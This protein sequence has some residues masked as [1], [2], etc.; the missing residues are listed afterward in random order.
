MDTEPR[1]QYQG[2]TEAAV[3]DALTE[4]GPNHEIVQEVFR[5]VA[6]YASFLE[7]HAEAPER[8]SLLVPRYPIQTVA[9]RLV[10]EALTQRK[11]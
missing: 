3:L 8:L 1:V 11:E 4:S 2:L 6:A 5:L 10:R 9:V 7:N